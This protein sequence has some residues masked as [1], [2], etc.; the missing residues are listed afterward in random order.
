VTVERGVD[1]AGLAL[2][3]FGGAGPLHAAD[4]A[5]ALGMAAVVIPARAGV[6]SAVGLLCSPRQRDLVRSWPEPLHHEGL[7]GALAELAGTA[8]RLVDDDA[9]DVEVAVDARYRGQSHELTVPLGL[10][11][12]SVDRLAEI[13]AERHRMFNGFDRLGA[14]VEVIAVRARAIGAPAIRF[15]DLP[16]PVR[17]TVVGPAVVVEPDCTVWVP[18]GWIGEPAGGGALVL[19][20]RHR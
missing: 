17:A 16:A 15:G 11:D 1:P 3:A 19:R 9:A 4:L 20:R 12:G 14:A 18:E 5:D 7:A 13:F 2:V 6:L 8:R 10:A